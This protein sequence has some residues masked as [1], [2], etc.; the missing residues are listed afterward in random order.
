MREPDS[1]C[2]W[3]LLPLRCHRASRR[4]RRHSRSPGTS[5]GIL[6][7]ARTAAHRP[8]IEWVVMFQEIRRSFRRTRFDASHEACREGQHPRLPLW[9]IDVLRRRPL[10]PCLARRSSPGHRGKD[11][12]RWRYGSVVTA[13][14]ASRPI[15][16]VDPFFN[17]N[18]P[19]DLARRIW[20]SREYPR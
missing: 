14:Q 2:E 19:E 20:V 15:E 12:R 17:I 11:M 6:D 8:R 3:K 18:T 5:A 10:A 13:S 16:T 1:Q 9:V 7:G 4:A